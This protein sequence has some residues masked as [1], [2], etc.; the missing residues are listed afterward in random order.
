MADTSTERLLLTVE[1]AARQ[2]HIGRTFAW[3]LVRKGELPVVRLGRCVRVP[4]QALQE[5]LDR[6]VEEGA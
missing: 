3:E 2:L 5:W 6:R 1:E 4:R